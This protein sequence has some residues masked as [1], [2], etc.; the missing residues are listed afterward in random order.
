MSLDVTGDLC[1]PVFAQDFIA[2]SVGQLCGHRQLPAVDSDTFVRAINC[3]DCF[4][5]SLLLHG[6]CLLFYR[7]CFVVVL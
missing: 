1:Q 5:F 4:S 2:H 3:P 7:L 6:V